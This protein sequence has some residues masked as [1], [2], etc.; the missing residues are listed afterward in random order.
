MKLEIHSIIDKGEFKGKKVHKVLSEDKK[1]IF[2]MLKEGI[3]F[4]DSVLEQAGIKKNV[5]SVTA[6]CSVVQHDNSELLKKLEIDKVDPSKIFEDIDIKIK[7]DNNEK[8]IIDE[9]DDDFDLELDD[10]EL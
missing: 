7:V 9:L 6:V 4:S 1:N 10:E 3:L 2:K 8:D 5:H